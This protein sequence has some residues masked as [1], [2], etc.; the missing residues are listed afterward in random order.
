MLL[1]GADGTYA[2]WDAVHRTLPPKLRP[3]EPRYGTGNL[4]DRMET[5]RRA[6]SERMVV[7][8]GGRRPTQLEIALHER[9]AAGR[10]LELLSPADARTKQ[11][12]LRWKRAEA[13][14][15]EVKLATEGPR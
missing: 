5:R 11:A 9:D 12:T 3:K 7:T 6:A 1:W 8:M 10:E 4:Q 13:R 15:N 2:V 14:V